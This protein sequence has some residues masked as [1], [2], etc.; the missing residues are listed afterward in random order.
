MSETS[1]IHAEMTAG[2]RFDLPAKAPQPCAKYAGVIAA[3]VSPCSSPGVIDSLAAERLCGQLAKHGCNGVFIASSTG[4]ALLLDEQDRRLLT[5]AARKALTPKT[6]IYAGVTG[7]GLKQTVRYAQNAA[8]DGAD[9]AVVMAPFLFKISQAEL[10]D[11]F[12]RIA[13]ASPIPIALYHHHKMSTAIS[14]ETV[15]RVAEHENIVAIKDTNPDIERTA[16]LIE[17]TA[18]KDFSVFQGNEVLLLE[19]LTRGAKGMVTAIANF[20]PESH[21]DLY[22]TAIAGNITEAKRHQA[23]IVRL[24]EILFFEPVLGSISAFA[25]CIKLAVKRRG[26]LDRTDVMLPGFVLDEGFQTMVQNHLAVLGVPTG[27]PIVEPI[28]KTL[29]ADTRPQVA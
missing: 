17:V 28:A 5:S 29:A 26:W 19:S 16:A 22:K 2:R 9:V 11:Y 23:Q 12:L 3:M 8:E 4:E 20:A 14:V 10:V 18:G 7:L 1:R 24:L 27:T 13:D 15:A 25:A 21:A 6:T